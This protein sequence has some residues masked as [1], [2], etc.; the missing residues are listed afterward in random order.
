MPAPKNETIIAP[1]SGWIGVNWRELW[2]HRE[3]LG[4]LV[5]RDIRVRYKQTVL[6]AF[7]AILQPLLSMIIFS[8]VFGRF[9]KMPSD[10]E[11]YALFVYA[12]LL[13]WTFIS[14]SVTQ[15]SQSLVNQ[16]HLLT[17]VYFPRLFVPAAPIGVALIDMAIASIGFAVMLV[18][19]QQAPSWRYLAIPCLL[20][21][22]VFV[23]LGTGLFLSSLTVTYRD[24]RHV[25]PFMLQVWMYAS[26]VVFPSSIVPAEYRWIFA[27]N[28]IAGIIDG[29]RSAIFDQ[30]FLWDSLGVSVL[31]STGLL[32]LGLFYF[33]R[34]ER[35]FADVA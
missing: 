27:L 20:V 35:R 26:P 31:V 4:L 25:V 3:L 16:Q 23:A 11:P 7:W 9:A 12:G 19:H 10:G 14:T 21:L 30:P 34:T 28:P 15:A 5:A 8:I 18:W 29:F 13:P 24:F 32:L 1:R 6:G 33:K 17:K 22:S 2:D